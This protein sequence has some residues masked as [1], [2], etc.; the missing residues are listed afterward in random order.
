MPRERFIALCALVLLSA[1]ACSSYPKRIDIWPIYFHEEIGDRKT[2]EIIWPIGGSK[3]I[4]GHSESGAWPFF[5]TYKDDDKPGYANACNG[6]YPFFVNRSDKVDSKLWV[7]PFFL[8][9]SREMPDSDRDID[10]MVFPLFFWGTSPPEQK[11]FAFFPIYG[12]LKNR[13]ARDENFFVLFP[14]YNHSRIGSRHAKNIL[15][16][17]I[18]WT[19]GGG[20][21]SHRVL[22]FY[23]YYKKE[24]EPE[25]WSFLWPIVHFSNSDGTERVPRHMFMIWP[26]FGWDNDRSKNRTLALWPLFSYDSVPDT[27]YYN[28]IGP[29]PIFRLQKGRELRRTQIWPIYGQLYQKG[30]HSYY[31]FWPIFRWEHK[32]AERIEQR[33]WSFALFL[34]NKYYRDKVADTEAVR[35]M[36]WP[37]WRYFRHHDGS[38]QFVAFSPIYY[39]DEFGFERNYSRFWRVFEYVDNP[40]EEETSYRFIWR[41]VRYDRLGKYS[42]LNVLGP[43]FR[44]EH[45]EE[46]QTKFSLLGGLLTVG[47]RGGSGVFKLFYIPFANGKDPAETN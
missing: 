23:T 9:T 34:Y 36:A 47:S 45:E 4:P 31:V 33:D 32:D 21:R 42:T 26:L 20:R 8:R 24:G 22:P 11:H 17:I 28:W 46:V 3:T 37:F 38:K 18:A 5:T 40:K 30:M 35:R 25:L 15:F 43:L 7:M 19:Y 27:D 39:W 1:G 12:T 29:W 6:I 14:I 41:V 44:Y 13:L 2:T 16:P 10:Y